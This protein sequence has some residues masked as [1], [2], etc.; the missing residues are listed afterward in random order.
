MNLYFFV[1]Y[2]EDGNAAGKPD[3][4]PPMPTRLSWELN[5][6][7]ILNTIEEADRDAQVLLNVRI[8]SRLTGTRDPAHLIPYFFFFRISSLEFSSTTNMVRVL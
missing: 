5:D 8:F 2:D 3:F 1:R 6:E 7:K 4:T